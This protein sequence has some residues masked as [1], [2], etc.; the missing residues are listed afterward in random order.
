LSLLT[1]NFILWGYQI[2]CPKSPQVLGTEGQKR[3]SSGVAAVR[4]AETA[5]QFCN[6]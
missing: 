3:R 2:T 1:L 5:P 6:S 4:K